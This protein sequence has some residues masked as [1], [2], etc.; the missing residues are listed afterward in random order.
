MDPKTKAT[1]Q[2][3]L[4]PGVAIPA[5]AAASAGASIYGNLLDENQLEK[6]DNRLITESLL[7]GIGAG[8][9]LGLGYKL[10]KN[11]TVRRKAADILMDADLP[12]QAESTLRR[13][14]PLLVGSALGGLGA[15]VASGPIANT[16]SGQA[17]LLGLP[18]FSGRQNDYYEEDYKTAT[19]NLTEEDILLLQQL[20]RNAS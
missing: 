8:A 9:G 2:M 6:G 19:D 4:R 10:R 5:G 20:I 15:S 12:P 11:P 18:S 1:L 7:S 3:L 14:Y 13:V 17:N 16:I